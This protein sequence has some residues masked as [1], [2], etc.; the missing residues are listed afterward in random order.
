MILLA[1][2]TR[3]EYIKLK[4]LIHEFDFNGFPYKTLFTG[5]HQD[6]LKEIVPDFSAIIHE[7]KGG[8]RLDA[9]IA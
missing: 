2:G 9:I 7:F 1:Y 3:P 5:Q 8:N 4:P 6:L